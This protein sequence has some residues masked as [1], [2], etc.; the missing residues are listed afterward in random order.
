MTAAIYIQQL[1]HFFGTQPVL[2][3][4]SFSIGSGKFF[5]IIGPHGAGNDQ[6]GRRQ[7]KQKSKMPSHGE[8]T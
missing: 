3:D 7:P 5:I 4:L 1:S 2:D 8:S 6:P